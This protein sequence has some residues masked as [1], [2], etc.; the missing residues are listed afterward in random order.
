MRRCVIIG[1]IKK[2]NCSMGNICYNPAMK[3]KVNFP[4]LV[5]MFFLSGCSHAVE[6]AKIFLGSSIQALE[7]ARKDAIVKTYVCSYDECFNAIVNLSPPSSAILPLSAAEKNPAPRPFTVFQKDLIKG[8]IVVMGIPG[9][10]DTTEVGIFL[11]MEADNA[12]RVEVASLSTSAKEKVAKI[13]FD[14]LSHHFT[15]QSST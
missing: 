12:I 11:I 10:I 7:E 3:M 1:L 5:L 15:E 14:E 13:V 4:I 8:Y 9:N 2:Q 6:S